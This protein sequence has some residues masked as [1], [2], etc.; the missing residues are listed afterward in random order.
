[1][2]LAARIARSRDEPVGEL[3]QYRLIC[4]IAVE[5]AGRDR[6]RHA[7]RRREAE[8]R[9]SV[10]MVGFMDLLAPGDSDYVV[11]DLKPGRYI[12]T[13]FLPKGATSMDDMGSADGE[14][15]AALGMVQESTV[16]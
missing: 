16:T 2:F 3:V 10:E 11:V 7:P 8:A 4:G 12:A 6:R 9:G 13:C 1:M 5:A 14:P 15:H